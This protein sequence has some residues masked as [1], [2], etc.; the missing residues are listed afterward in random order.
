MESETNMSEVYM[1]GMIVGAV[2]IVAIVLYAIDRRSK[3]EAIDVM[4]AA[5]VGGGAGVLAG[6]VVYA[7]GGAEAAEPV[8]TAVQ[9]MFTGKPSF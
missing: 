3:E 4:D 6:G 1:Y 5:K 2:V 8:M 9:D 7:L